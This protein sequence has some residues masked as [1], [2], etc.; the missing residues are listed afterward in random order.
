MCKGEAMIRRSIYTI[1]IFLLIALSSGC[2]ADSVAVSKGDNAVS[3][4][5]VEKAADGKNYVN[6][7]LIDD[8][9][10]VIADTIV[11]IY[12]EPDVKSERITQVLY[13]QPV[14]ILEDKGSWL[15][16]KSV[17]GSSGWLRNKFIDRNVLSVFGGG[18]ANKII[19]TSKD[20]TIYTHPTSGITQKNVVLGTEL[21]TFNRSGTAY[22]VYL[23]GNATGWIRGSGIIQIGLKDATSVTSNKDF[24]ASVIKFKG[25]SYLKNGMSSL[26]I[27]SMGMVYI[28]ARINGIDLPRSLKAL[29]QFGDRIE[30]ND[31]EAGDLVFL[32][33]TGEEKNITGI[34][35]STGNGQY[36]HSSKTSGYVKLDGLNE[37]GTDGKPVFARRIFN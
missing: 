21:Y 34:G 1:F 22:E 25:T 33:F 5:T 12:K 17:D 27:D 6:G 23:P 13:N 14:R 32:S 18:V 28:C 31:V 20:K 2:G 3:T 10:A 16:V 4:E 15:R 37:S 26:G 29:S 9:T 24:V 36:I 35:V 30:I 7:I 8:S 19:V 11:D